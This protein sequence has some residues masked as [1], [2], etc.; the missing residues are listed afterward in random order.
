VLD[1]ESDLPE[2]DF[3]L[4]DNPVFFI[5]TAADYVL[6]MQD[7]AASAPRGQPPE[8]FIAYLKENHPADIP[9]LLGFRQHLQDDPLSSM[10]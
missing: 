6:F 2:H 3:I 9:V 1:V 5:R 7:F 8:K 10:Y 4:A